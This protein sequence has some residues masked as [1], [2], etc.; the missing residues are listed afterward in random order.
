MMLSDSHRTTLEGFAGS[1]A[2]FLGLLTSMQE[3][4]EYSLRIL[5]LII[6]IA[7]GAVTLY[8]SLFRKQ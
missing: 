8:R 3:Q 5:S 2:S 6:G 4:L 7:V 1:T